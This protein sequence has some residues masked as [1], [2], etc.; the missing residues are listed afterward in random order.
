MNDGS[1]PGVEVHAVTPRR[2]DRCPMPNCRSRPGSGA[3]HHA[4]AKQETLLASAGFFRGISGGSDGDRLATFETRRVSTGSRVRPCD[5]RVRSSGR[6][7]ADSLADDHCIRSSNRMMIEM[8]IESCWSLVRVPLGVP[9][10]S[11]T[12]DTGGRRP[13]RIGAKRNPL[14]VAGQGMLRSHRA[15]LRG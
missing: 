9:R 14:M 8:S 11:R 2:L 13:P 10:S 7:T 12:A 6:L 1:L 4:G 15:R 3:R 5:E